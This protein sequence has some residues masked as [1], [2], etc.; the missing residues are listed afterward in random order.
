VLSRLLVITV[1]ARGLM[2]GI[3][4]LIQLLDHNSALRRAGVGLHDAAGITG[5]PHASAASW[6][7]SPDA[8][9]DCLSVATSLGDVART[10]PACGLSRNVAALLHMGNFAPGVLMRSPAIHLAGPRP[11]MRSRPRRFLR[12]WRATDAAAWGIGGSGSA[13]HLMGRSSLA[14]HRPAAVV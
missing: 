14:L 2:D 13:A 9:A 5:A 7:T 10:D 6:C 4:A 12:I 1:P 3:E 8:A 11:M